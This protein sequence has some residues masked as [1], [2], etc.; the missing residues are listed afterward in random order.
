MTKKSKSAKKAPAR[1]AAAK[2]SAPKE[3][4]VSKRDLESIRKK[5]SEQREEVLE[6]MKRNRAPEV[7]S[8]TGDEAD[9][10]QAA[11]DRDLQ[12]ELS[13]TERNMLD[14]IEG[15]LRKMDKG[16]FGLCEQCRNPIEALRI[17]ALPFA[18]YCIRCQT[19]SER[20]LTSS[21]S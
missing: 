12:F 7:T 18:R 10:A 16:T 9:Q 14:Q 8:D 11:M 5:L 21:A 1:K 3:P 15:A 6:A 17:K 20:A 13:D 4:S 2:P 19:G